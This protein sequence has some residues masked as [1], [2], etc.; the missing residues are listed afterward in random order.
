MLI[1][2]ALVWVTTIWAYWRLLGS[3]REDGKE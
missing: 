3:P 2:L 1:S